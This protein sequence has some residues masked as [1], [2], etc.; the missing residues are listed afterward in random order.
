LS[1]ESKLIADLLVA[2]RDLSEADMDREADRL[3]TLVAGRVTLI[4]GDGRVVGDSTQT[5]AELQSLENHAAR[6]EVLNAGQS[7]VGIS[8]R[9]STTLQT[10]MV[11]VAIR[12]NH[13]V[14]KYVRLALP[15]TDVNAQLA[16]IGSATILALVA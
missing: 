7:T 5:P 10:D 4:A 13:P 12:S 11:Y 15:L 14:V 8:Q 2:A 1:D 9:Y 6:P 16:T 3:G